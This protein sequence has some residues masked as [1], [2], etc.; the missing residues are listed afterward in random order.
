[1]QEFKKALEI[2]DSLGLEESNQAYRQMQR[3]AASFRGLGLGQTEEAR[4][5]Q[6][7][8]AELDKI[9]LSKTMTAVY[10][11]IVQG[12]AHQD[13]AANGFPHSHWTLSTAR[14]ERLKPEHFDVSWGDADL[15][16]TEGRE[17]VLDEEAVQ[18][19]VALKEFMTEAGF[20]T[21]KGFLSP[22]HAVNVPDSARKDMG[23]P[24][25]AKYFMFSYTVEH[26]SSQQQK[27]RSRVSSDNCPDHA[28]LSNGG[29][30]YLDETRVNIIQMNACFPSSGPGICFGPPKRWNPDWTSRLV[31][32]GR[33]RTL[34]RKLP[35]VRSCSLTQVCWIRPNEV[36]WA[37]GDGS[38]ICPFGG[39][40]YI[41]DPGESK[42][43]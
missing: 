24:I 13:S 7:R 22:L 32:A 20:G 35:G 9:A 5:I 12:A 23:I 17:W 40:A 8:I 6:T 27:K 30:V 28:F 34:S 42:V 14:T 43:G 31:R 10:F 21:I 37:D 15:L 38:P 16:T 19:D 36:L 11:E 2:S 18:H 39:F 29:F 3:I 4:E 26:V 41:E 1:L 25:E 33:F